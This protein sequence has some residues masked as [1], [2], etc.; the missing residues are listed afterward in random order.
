MF[1]I[2]SNSLENIPFDGYLR[3]NKHLLSSDDVLH[4]KFCESFTQLLF[5][6]SKAAI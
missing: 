1:F 2:S 3:I 5:D 4:T 6:C